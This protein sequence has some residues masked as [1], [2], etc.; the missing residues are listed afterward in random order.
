MVTYTS[1]TGYSDKLSENVEPL[2]VLPG[3]FA[4]DGRS[5]HDSIIVGIGFEPFSLISW[6]SDQK[7]GRIRL[8]FPFPPGPPG[9]V[10][11]WMF[12]KEIEKRTRSGE[13]SPPDCMHIHMYDCP[14]VFEAL[15]EMTDNG[16]QRTALAPY[17]PKTVSLAMC[18][19]ALAAKA[20]GR[21][22][23]PVYYAQPRRYNLDYT[24]QARMRGD[25]PDIIGYCLRLAGRDLYT[26]PKVK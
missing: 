3:F 6:L 11:N 1:A 15:C 23:V 22:R 13:I 20:A 16:C 9:H 14:Q 18:L 5:Q 4:E 26:L 21:S 24:S 2:R 17:G 7:S 8:I 25:V 12:V 10:R 19:F